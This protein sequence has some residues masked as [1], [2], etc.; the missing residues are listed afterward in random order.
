MVRRPRLA[1]SLNGNTLLLVGIAITVSAHPKAQAPV[2]GQTNHEAQAPD[3]ASGFGRGNFAAAINRSG[4]WPL[5][6]AAD[7]C[8]PKLPLARQ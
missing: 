7:P 1:G 3:L 5:R 6:H 8:A 4:E 2:R